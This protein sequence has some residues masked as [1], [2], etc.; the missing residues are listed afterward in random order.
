MRPPCRGM[1]AQKASVWFKNGVIF[2][3]MQQVAV[4]FAFSIIQKN[5]DIPEHR[6]KYVI[7]CGMNG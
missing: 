5:M 2:W 3:Q 4:G 7:N 6:K 1:A